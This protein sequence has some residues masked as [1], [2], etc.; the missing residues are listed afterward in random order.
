[1]PRMRKLTIAAVNIATD[2]PHKPDNYRRLFRF[3]RDLT[4][5]A[6]GEIRGHDRLTLNY[7]GEK[8][9]VLAGAFAR[10]THIDPNSSWWD[11]QKK[12]VLLDKE[13]KPITPVRQGLGPNHQDINFTMFLIGHRL[14]FDV[15]SITPSSFAKG[16]AGIFLDPRVQEEFGNIHIT[17]EP[18][19]DAIK[20]ILKMPIKRRI[21]IKFTMPNPDVAT[22][23]EESI[24]KRYRQ[25]GASSTSTIVTAQQDKNLNPDKEMIA[26]MNLASRN[27]FVTITGKN[28]Q[29]GKDIM[30]SKDH[31]KTMDT[32]Y[33]ENEDR[34]GV[35]SKL[36]K[37]MKET[38]LPNNVRRQ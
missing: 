36:A 19:R 17:V 13:G 3:I 38:L 2:P 1:M 4:P 24:M 30:S 31:P 20:R 7:F 25:I 33:P 6:S 28:A 26:L 16:L 11:V 27:G 18:E 5:A 9:N 37:K 35:F 34:W 12:T 14:I 15:K 22:E 29:G 10:Y 21:E 32:S 23:L 8:G